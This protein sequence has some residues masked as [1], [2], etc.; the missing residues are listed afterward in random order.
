MAGGVSLSEEAQVLQAE[1]RRDP[2]RVRPLLSDP[3]PQ[4]RARAALAL[5]RIAAPEDVPRLAEL[6]Q[7]GESEVRASAAFALGLSGERSAVEPLRDLVA[8]PGDPDPMVRSRAVAA[9]IRLGGQGVAALLQ[10]VLRGEGEPARQA[11]QDAWKLQDPQLV[12]AVLDRVADRDPGLRGA[13]AYSLMRMVGP[14]Q[15]GATPVPGGTPMSQELRDQAAAVLV[16]LSLDRNERIRELAARGLGGGELPGALDA[17]L[18]LLTDP[19]W[20]VRV[21]A[22]TALGRIGTGF[23]PDVLVTP[24]SDDHLNVR[25]AAITAARPAG[26]T[27]ALSRRLGDL[28]GATELPIRAAAEQTLASWRGTGFLPRALELSEDEQ[29]ALRTVAATLLGAIPGGASRSRLRNMLEDDGAGVAEA[30]L[31]ALAGREGADLAAL[32]LAVAGETDDAMMRAAAVNLLPGDWAGLLALLENIWQVARSDAQNDARIAIVRRLDLIAGADGTAL[33]EQILQEDPDW[34]VRVEAAAVLRSRGAGSTT[35][36]PLDTGKEPAD[37]EAV[38]EAHDLRVEL[39][40]ERGNIVL[41]LFAKDAPLTVAS[42]VS[43]V[44]NGFYDG[45]TFHRVVPNFVIQGGDPRGDG[46]GGPGYQI[47]CEINERP[48]RRGTLGMALDG[49]DTGGSQF[50]ITHAP[51]PHLDGGYT[52]FGQ[53]VE[54]MVVVDSVVQGDVIVSARVLR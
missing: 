23:D 15:V 28:Q 50:F 53:V 44:E 30:A 25:L 6:L 10:P 32:G 24:L 31:N 52:V 21:N 29:P 22:V 38:L 47:R 3:R 34:R 18:P 36:G 33:L 2:T 19:S 41:E 5:G 9:V 14:P 8:E 7:D 48:Y 39:Q 4:V 51:Q 45:L 13:A 49:K 20:R 12:S 1:D 37:Y 27:P 42:F 26:E 35:A 54:G 43:L 40:L 11:L 16:V 17:L 46:W